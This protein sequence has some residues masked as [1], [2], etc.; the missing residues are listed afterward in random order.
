M[1]VECS[2]TLPRSHRVCS[3]VLGA[4]LQGGDEFGGKSGPTT[5]SITHAIWFEPKAGSL[6]YNQG[7]F[8]HQAQCEPMLSKG[9]VVW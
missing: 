5:V 1:S 8:Q 9:N 4:L 3:S 6:G 7:E 2:L